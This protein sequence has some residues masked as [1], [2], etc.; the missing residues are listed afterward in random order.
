ML[1]ITCKHAIQ[2]Q[3]NYKFNISQGAF[4]HGNYVHTLQQHCNIMAKHKHIE[5]IWLSIIHTTNKQVN[6]SYSQAWAYYAG[7]TLRIVHYKF[8]G[9]NTGSRSLMA[10]CTETC[11][12]LNWW[13]IRSSNAASQEELRSVSD[14]I[15][16]M[17]TKCTNL[18]A[19]I[20]TV[21]IIITDALKF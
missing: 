9:N 15:I 10:E 11:H 12:I 13:W 1:T 20:W 8:G 14:N 17:Y 7:I 18:L 3:T 4:W 21:G 19:T 6:Y 16:L 5:S 2:V